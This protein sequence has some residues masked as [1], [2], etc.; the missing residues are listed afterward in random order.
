MVFW[1]VVSQIVFDRNHTTATIFILETR[2]DLLGL[3]LDQLRAPWRGGGRGH[4]RLS[5][6]I[7]R[8]GGEYQDIC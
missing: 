3:L 7:A 4:R 2:L 5:V 8:L 1:G 6:T